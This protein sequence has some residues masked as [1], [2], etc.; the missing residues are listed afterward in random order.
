[1]PPRRRR[2]VTQVVVDYVEGDWRSCSNGRIS[3]IKYV[4]ITKYLRGM[5]VREWDEE[6]AEW[7]TPAEDHYSGAGAAAAS[8]EDPVDPAL[9]VDQV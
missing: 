2:P 3:F 9:A 7:S 4:K 8:A 6:W 1:M 5:I